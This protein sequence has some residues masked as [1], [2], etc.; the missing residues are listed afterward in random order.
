MKR[1]GAGILLVVGTAMTILSCQQS[2]I[3]SEF[4]GNEVTYALA[5]GSQY[6]ISGTIVFK[7]RKDEKLLPQLHCRVQMAT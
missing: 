5:Q 3:V 6:A 7:E 1:I 2:D 4:T